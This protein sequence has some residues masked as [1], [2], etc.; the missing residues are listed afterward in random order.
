ML[1]FFVVLVFSLGVNIFVSP[2]CPFFQSFIGL[3]KRF[4]FIIGLAMMAGDALSV[5]AGLARFTREN[6]FSLPVT[7][8]LY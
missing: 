1:L 7:G 5:F 4:F 8:Q 6:W 2:R 3:E